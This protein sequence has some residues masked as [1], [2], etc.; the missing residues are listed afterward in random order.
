MDEG[1]D[2]AGL[3]CAVLGA[4]GAGRA[5]A[6][7]LGQAGAADVAVVPLG[8]DATQSIETG[9]MLVYIRHEESSVAGMSI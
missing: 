3:R 4:G 9:D 5:V 1:V 6:L 2:P 8:G 7:A